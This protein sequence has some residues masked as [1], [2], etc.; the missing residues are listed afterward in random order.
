MV[1][2]FSCFSDQM[3]EWG[4]KCDLSDFDCGMIVGARQGGLNIS[5]TADLLG[6]SY[7]AVSRVCRGGAKNKKHPVCSSSA[8]KMLLERSRSRSN[9]LKADRK[10]THITTVVCRRASLNTQCV[11]PLKWIGYSSR[12]P[13]SLKL[14]KCLIKCS[15]SVYLILK[16]F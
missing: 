13:I 14:N 5:E 15:L 12:R 11:K 10:V 16:F 1:K 7:N 3:S 2:R 6:F 8:G 4:K 9:W